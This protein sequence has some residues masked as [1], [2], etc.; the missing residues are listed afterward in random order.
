MLP[1]NQTAGYA[2]LALGLMPDPG[3]QPVLVRDIAEAA[4]IPKP[5]LSKLVHQLAARGL[6]DTRRGYKGGVTLA[7]PAAEITLVEIAEAVGGHPMK[8]PCVLGLAEC[9]D[10]CAC[11]LHEFWCETIDR[12]HQKLSE[13]TLADTAKFQCEQHARENMLLRPDEIKQSLAAHRCA[14][15]SVP[16]KTRIT[17]NPIPVETSSLKTKVK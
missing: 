10:E 17:R 2:V 6:I 4:D 15:P 11:P 1:L 12:V 5:Y 13:T 7:R 3:N 16:G 14:G 9:S 8:Y